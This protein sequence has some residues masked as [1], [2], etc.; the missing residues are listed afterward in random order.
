MQKIKK[1]RCRQNKQNEENNVEYFKYQ[2]KGQLLFSGYAKC[3]GCGR[4]L[5]TRSSKREYKKEDGTKGY[6]RYLYYGCSYSS[7]G[8][9][10]KNTKKSYKNNT[11]EEP[12]MKEIYK[13][14]DLLEQRDLSEYIRNVQRHNIDNEGKQLIEIEKKL[15]ECLKKN[16][17]LKE[18][19]MKAITGK[20]E[21]SKELI[22][23]MME[24]NNKK[25]KEY[26]KKKNKLELLKQQK[27]IEFEQLLKLKKLI[28][29]WKVV[30]E[31][32]SIEQ[33]K[34]ILAS[35]IKEIIVYDDKIDVKLNISLNEFINTA[36]KLQLKNNTLFENLTNRGTSKTNT[37]LGACR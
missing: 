18:E 9:D 15:R 4:L 11:I 12:I 1:S 23:E 28:P 13:Y 20:S 25:I 30:F 6:K 3:G 34:M 10:C 14:F 17:L 37:N 29:D 19:V 27:D 36:N 5:T 26:T 2:T 33:K 35:I 24:E 16:E 32:S 7:C 22:S 31:N 21:F 8:G